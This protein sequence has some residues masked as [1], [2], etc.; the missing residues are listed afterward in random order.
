[1]KSLKT[2]IFTE[3]DAFEVS[4]PNDATV[5]QKALLVG[6]S[7]FVNANFFEERQRRGGGGE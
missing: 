5:D 6:T 1:M 2:E 4:F 7:I 3:A